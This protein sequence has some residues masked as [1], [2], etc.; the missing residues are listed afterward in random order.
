M[1]S[2][3]VWFWLYYKNVIQ[4]SLKLKGESYGGPNSVDINSEEF[5]SLPPEMKHE[6]LKDM[7]EFSKRRRTM[8]QKP[9]EVLF[10]CHSDSTYSPDSSSPMQTPLR[11]LLAFRGLFPVPVGWSAAEEP[12][13]PAL[14]GGG[15]R[16]EPEERRRCAT[17]LRTGRRGAESQR[18]VAPTG[19]RRPFPLYTN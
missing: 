14:G 13:E 7:K 11:S 19:F 17:A 4:F 18:G 10:R 5:A 8:Y 3:L 9:P 6:I 1:A 2:T 15:E 12:L 16:D